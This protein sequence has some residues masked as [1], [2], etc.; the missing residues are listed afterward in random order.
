MKMSEISMETLMALSYQEMWDICS[1][2]IY[3]AGD[4]ADVA[5]LL[6]SKPERA[7]E[8]AL[9]AAKLFHAGRV[10]TIIPSGGVKWEFRGNT[11][12]EAEIMR[13]I[14]LEEGVPAEAVILENEARTTL[15]NMTFGAALIQ[16][17]YL[18]IPE[19]VIIV[20]SLLHMKRSL[21]L[22]KNTF[23]KETKI[24]MYPAFPAVD[25]DTWLSIAEN[26]KHLCDGLRL[27]KELV[28]L[29]E[30]E[31]MEIKLYIRQ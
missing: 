16:D 11:F 12:S 9:A 10:K 20:T 5:L 2:G 24:S 26:Q 25:W 29:G 14:L 1:A 6:G 4:T 22:A 30:A 19:C 7:V 8:R 17:K 18:Q 21:A 3:D 13:Q 15:Q 27:L 31:D 28:D 23:P